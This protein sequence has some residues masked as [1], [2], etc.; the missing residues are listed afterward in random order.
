MRPQRFDHQLGLLPILD[1]RRFSD[2]D[3]DLRRL[4]VAPRNLIQNEF[5]KL[6]RVQRPG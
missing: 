1:Q 6:F 4:Q 2:F 5:N 3:F